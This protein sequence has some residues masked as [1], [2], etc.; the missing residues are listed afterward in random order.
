MV[1]KV[2]ELLPG[3]RLQNIS[4]L[5]LQRKNSSKQDPLKYSYDIIELCYTNADFII[6][7]YIKHYK[8]KHSILLKHP[9]SKLSLVSSFK[10]IVES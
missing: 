5:L 8:I 9:V 2:A 3:Q 4:E 7:F 6:W 10:H 1:L